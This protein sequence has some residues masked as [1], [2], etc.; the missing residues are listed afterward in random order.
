MLLDLIILFGVAVFLFLAFI[1]CI[2]AS[3]GEFGQCSSCGDYGYTKPYWS[4]DG[5]V[6]YICE[7]LECIQE[8]LAS[9]YKR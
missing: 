8:A 2:L 6:F 4:E 1:V 9:G 7:K 5:V 3:P